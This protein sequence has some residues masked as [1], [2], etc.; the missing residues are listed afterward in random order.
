M[1][2]ALPLVLCAALIIPTGC[3]NIE[4]DSTRTK[5]EGA[6]VGTA[7]GAAAGAAIGKATG[8]TGL[9]LII[10][11]GVG[12]IGGFFV[13]KHIADKKASY[14]SR[15]D[16]LDACIVQAQ[17]TNTKL[18]EYNTE[19][20]A[21]IA[22][23]DQETTRLAAAYKRQEVSSRAL[24][25]ESKKIAKQ[26]KDAEKIIAGLQEEIAKQKT[27]AVDAREGNNTREADIIEHEI[28]KME[29]QIAELREESSKLASM[30]LR[31]S[32]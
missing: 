21:Q 32:I 3:A 15:E 18:A 16:W 11:A 20:K 28:A 2:K 25:A 23:I 1:K 22:S 6:L 19:L 29:S 26:Q 17:D 31:V 13:G 30:S 10:G 9:G 24:Q 4:N 12:L 5:T 27:V 7:A 14:A 8:N